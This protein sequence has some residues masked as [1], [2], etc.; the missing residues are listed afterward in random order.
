MHTNPANINVSNKF[1]SVHACIKIVTHKIQVK[2]LDK[3][4]ASTYDKLLCKSS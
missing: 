3:Y 2:G 4:Q 1:I